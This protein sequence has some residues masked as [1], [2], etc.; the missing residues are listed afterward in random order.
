MDKSIISEVA[1]RVNDISYKDFDSSIYERCLLRASRKVAKRYQLIQR[2]YKFTSRI[3]IPKGEDEQAYLEEKVKEVI[4]LAIPSFVSEYLVVINDMQYIKRD[5]IRINENEY[6]FKRDHNSINFNYT[7]RTKEDIVEIHYT[8]DIN[9]D[10]YDVQEL[11]PI[12]PSQYN[13]ELI[14][15]AIVEV[16]KM[17]IVKFPNSEKGN[18]YKEAL[19]IYGID[20]R[21]LDR[22]LLTNENWAEIKIWQPY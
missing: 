12:I 4:K 11:E 14:A 13:E 6:Y 7:P 22:K 19:S 21:S 16:S 9:E 10:D 15:L 3:S 2:Y 5:N 20:E 1:L 18:K 17:G 8:S